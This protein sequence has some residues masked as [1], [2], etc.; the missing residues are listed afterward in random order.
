M[1]QNFTSFNTLLW[2]GQLY[3]TRFQGY[4]TF[5]SH[6]QAMMKNS[7]V[8]SNR[9]RNKSQVPLDL[10]RSKTIF[11]FLLLN[12]EKKKIATENN[13]FMMSKKG[14]KRLTWEVTFF[15]FKFYKPQRYRSVNV[16]ATSSQHSIGPSKIMTCQTRVYDSDG[17]VILP[18]DLVWIL[19]S[20]I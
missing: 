12:T 3:F 2:V 1:H 7:T 10:H 11:F 8:R 15:L 14:H 16:A 20:E 9:Q 17:Q 5:R 6:W 13:D 4:E 19:V 18:G